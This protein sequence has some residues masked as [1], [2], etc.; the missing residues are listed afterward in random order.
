MAHRNQLTKDDIL[1]IAGHF[2][3]LEQGSNENIRQVAL[4][5]TGGATATFKKDGEEGWTVNVEG[6]PESADY[7]GR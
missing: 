2:T 1:T 6:R 3:I 4:T 7:F 5:L